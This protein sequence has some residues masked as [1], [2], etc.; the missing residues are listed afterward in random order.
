MTRLVRPDGNAM[1]VEHVQGLV[2]KSI[3]NINKHN[4]EL[5]DE[6]TL[7]ISKGDDRQGH[8]AKV[9]YDAIHVG[10]SAPYTTHELIRQLEAGRGLDILVINKFDHEMN[11]YDKKA[12][13]TY[14]EQRHM[15]VIYVQLKDE[16]KPI[17]KLRS[18]MTDFNK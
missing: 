17:R 13:G 7:E 15:S 11:I 5:F 2:D 16:K 8:V 4:K 12:N 18:S 6:C 14:V 3:Q 1:G 9:P 10:S